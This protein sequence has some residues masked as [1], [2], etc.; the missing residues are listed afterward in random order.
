MLGPREERGPVRVLIVEDEKKVAAAV[1]RG[2]EAEGFAVDVALTGTDGL[3]MASEHAY[4][5]IV[6]D[7]L[8]P[9]MNGYELC[10]KLR[11]A[12]NWTP[13]LMLTAKSGEYDQAEALDTGADDFLSKPFSFVVLLAR[14]RALLRRSGRSETV[15]YAAGDVTLDPVRHRCARGDVEVALTAREFSVLEFLMRRAG[16]VVTKSEILDNVWDFAFEGDPNIVEVY[17][18]HLRKKLDE[19]FNRRLIETIRGAGYRL[20]RRGG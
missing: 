15:I 5:V 1:R 20:D 9:G 3:W 11:E 19:P 16:E 2:L 10:R 4:D 14:L 7:I 18:R 13:I 17:V 8:L 6:L 12:S